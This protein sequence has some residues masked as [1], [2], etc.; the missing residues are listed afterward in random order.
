MES[1]LGKRLVGEFLGS[2]LTALF[3]FMAVATAV[4]CGALDL[5]GVGII[6]AAAITLA[7]YI[8]IAVS[9]ASFNPAVT[10]AFAIFGGF[11]KKDVIPYWI[12]QI[13]GWFAGAVLTYAVFGGMI[14]AYEASHG[15][16]RGTLASQQTAMIFNCYAPH[17]LIALANNWDASVVPTWK[18]I[19]NEFF[20]TALL[21]VTVFACVD[22][23]NPFRPKAWIFAPVIGIIVALLIV[24]ASP[25]SMAC[26]NPARDFGPR[27]ATYLLGWGQASFPG[28]PSGLGGPWWLFWV[29]PGLGAIAGGALWKYVVLPC[30]PKAEVV[31]EKQDL[32]M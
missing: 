20:A 32:S 3:G 30:L 5:F 28:G 18:G 19:L 23:Q 7:I 24:V 21:L 2:G 8:T 6:F 25:A 4:V 16:V 15:I 26:I 13:A 17:P 10:L 22:E 11:P 1:S 27:I 31:V 14:T 29:G 9:G 12:A